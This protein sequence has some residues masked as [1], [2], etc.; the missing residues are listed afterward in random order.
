MFKSECRSAANYLL[1]DLKRR[2]KN[3]TDSEPA[4]DDEIQLDKKGPDTTQERIQSLQGEI[5]AL[6]QI[7]CD[8]L[9]KNELLRMRL[10]QAHDNEITFIDRQMILTLLLSGNRDPD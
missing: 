6:R 4:M 5:D 2:S 9:Y 1:N 3:I 8:L 10:G 7:V